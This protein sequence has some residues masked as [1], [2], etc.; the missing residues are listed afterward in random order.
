[1]KHFMYAEGIYYSTL[2]DPTNVR[3]IQWAKRSL[4]F[5]SSRAILIDKVFA[6]LVVWNCNIRPWRVYGFHG[7][8]CAHP[9]H[10]AVT[11]LYSAPFSIISPTTLSWPRDTGIKISC[12]DFE[13]LG[14][15]SV[16]LISC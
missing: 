12:I 6:M 4:D 7:L 2:S 1:M 11:L 5:N 3:L 8:G 13:F 14:K 15:R 9:R 16:N 10:T